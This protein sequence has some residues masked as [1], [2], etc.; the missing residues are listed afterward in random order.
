[1]DVTYVDHMGT[2][3]TVV[4]SARVSFDK[5]SDWAPLEERVI[6]EHDQYLEYKKQLKDG[7]VKLINYLAK[8]KHWTPF[9]HCTATF[10]VK[11]P[12]FVA[13]QLFKHKVGL[14]ENEISRRY[15]D[16]E[17]ELYWPKVWRKRAENA[18]QGSSSEEYH[19]ADLL[20]AENHMKGLVTIYNKLVADGVAP[21]QARLV[22]PQGMYTEWFW[23]GSMSAWDRVCA[24]RT[25]EDAQAESR[26]IASMISEECA[27]LWP[28]SWSALDGVT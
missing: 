2:D 18:K 6:N 5:E 25:T 13:R 20:W 27:K 19:S 1:M 3:I 8:H 10:R 26:E 12:I 7:D 17:P 24:L 28:V 15:V 14:T 23:T 4:N 9:S 16:S 22:L 11:A 21:E